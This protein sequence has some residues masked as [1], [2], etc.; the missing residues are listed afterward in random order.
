MAFDESTE[1]KSGEGAREDFRGSDHL[2]E[3]GHIRT[4]FDES[5][6][7]SAKGEATL[8]WF[9]M[10]AMFLKKRQST[11]NVIVESQNGQEYD[12]TTRNPWHET[13]K[14]MPGR[15]EDESPSN[16]TEQLRRK[17]GRQGDAI[18]IT[19]L[20]HEA[21]C[22]GRNRR[23]GMTENNLPISSNMTRTHHSAEKMF[24]SRRQGQQ[25]D[26]NK[27]FNYIN[28]RLTLCENGRQR[29]QYTLMEFLSLED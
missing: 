18:E 3:L 27:R 5:S 1:K 29:S 9:E 21:I 10:K 16:R 7:N 24:K 17:V 23:T 19:W 8:D 4:S 2:V 25:M 12:Q 26:S 22:S 13:V 28:D 14:R 15:A 11:N 20:R 6:V